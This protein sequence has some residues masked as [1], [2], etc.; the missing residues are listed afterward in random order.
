MNVE[1]KQDLIQ[2]DCDAC[3]N[4]DDGITLERLV[5]DDPDIFMF[6]Q[7]G[8]CFCF[9]IDPLYNW[10]Y[11]NPE[12][13]THSHE[14]LQRKNPL[15]NVVM[16][17]VILNAI[18]AKYR[19]KHPERI[20]LADERIPIPVNGELNLYNLQL[21]QLPELPDDL[22]ILKCERNRLR[23]LPELP[24]G[25][26]RLDCGQNRLRVLP[27]LPQSLTDLKCYSNE[28]KE[29]PELPQR[30]TELYCGSNILTTLP[31][32]P[33]TLEDLACSSN[34][35]TE[36]P[37]LPDTLKN[38]VCVSNRL[39][40]IPDLPQRLTELYCGGNNLTTLPELPDTL[41]TLNCAE[42][43]LRELPE[44]PR[45]L[46]HLNCGDNLVVLTVRRTV[47]QRFPDSFE[48]TQLN[49]VEDEEFD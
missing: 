5:K 45:R 21:R 36:L 9:T 32:L 35:L 2:G 44:L 24:R 43:S 6:K 15:N 16:N 7:N 47:L 1:Q 38:L 23:V 3:S 4:E 49:I 19:A 11:V 30:L 46:E 42:N 8:Y 22:R 10:I 31:N 48:D 13:H 29:L 34:R 26:E 33:D 27:I 41:E 17:Q 25:L 37:E 20:Q 28:L 40:E 12:N 18:K 14:P 39:T